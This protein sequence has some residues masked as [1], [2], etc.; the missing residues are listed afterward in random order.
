MHLLKLDRAPEEWSRVKIFRGK[1][2]IECINGKSFF[3]YLQEKTS[4]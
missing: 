1:K 3:G 4:D 2:Q